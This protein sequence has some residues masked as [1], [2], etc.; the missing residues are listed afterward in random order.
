MV[1]LLFLSQFRSVISKLAYYWILCW[2]VDQKP[3]FQLFFNFVLGKQTSS[4]HRNWRDLQHQNSTIRGSIW[5]YNTKLGK[6]EGLPMTVPMFRYLQ[7]NFS[8]ISLWSDESWSTKIECSTLIDKIGKY[9]KTHY[10]DHRFSAPKMSWDLDSGHSLNTL[11]TYEWLIIWMIELMDQVDK[12]NDLFLM[13][14][15]FTINH[16][17]H[18]I[19]TSAEMFIWNKFK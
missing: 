6:R 2:S 19:E 4:K 12:F 10:A 14:N 5:W 3:N 16:W 13:R 15:L 9:I 17:I 1:P 8:L 11:N 7:C 18:N